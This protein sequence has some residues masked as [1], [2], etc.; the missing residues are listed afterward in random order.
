MLVPAKLN[1]GNN[2]ARRAK[3]KKYF[4]ENFFIQISERFLNTD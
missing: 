3:I 2:I 4:V 1:T